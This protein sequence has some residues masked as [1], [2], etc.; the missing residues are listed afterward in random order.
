MMLP[1]EATRDRGETSIQ[2]VLLV[3][4]MLGIFLLCLHAT[5]LAH[6]SHVA[7][8]AAI[9]AAQAAAFSDSSG[10]DIVKALN[11][12]EQVVTDLGSHVAGAP[13]IRIDANSVTVTVSVEVQSL[14][15]FLPTSVTRTAT[16]SREQFQFE[17][18]R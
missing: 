17:Q 18:D 10:N 2:T 3:P 14:I 1:S 5:A 7:S 12:A 4:I 15:S 16:V 6:G 8:A 9:R 11:E 13:Q